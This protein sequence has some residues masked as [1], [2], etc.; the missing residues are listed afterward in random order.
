MDAIYGESTARAADDAKLATEIT[1]L[2]NS[3]SITVADINNHKDNIANP[4]HVTKG[5]VEL[6][7]VENLPLDTEPLLESPNYITSNAVAKVKNDLVNLLTAHKE[8]TNNP[9]EVTKDQV[10]LDKLE[11]RII[12][13][14]V[15]D[16]NNYISA[17]GVK[18]AVD[19][20]Q[21]NLD[22]H[23]VLENNPHNVTA[24]QIKLEKVVNM[25]MDDSP[26]DTE[27]YVKSR[28]VKTAIDTVQINLDNHKSASNPHD[29]TKAK[30]GL[31][32]VVNA[33]MD[34]EPTTDSTNY[35]TSGGVASTIA[36]MKTAINYDISLINNKLDK[37]I[38]K[39]DIP[40]HLSSFSN[41][42]TNYITANQI[43]EEYITEEKLLAKGYLSYVPAEYITES[44][45]DAKGYI[46][47][48]QDI[49]G[50]VNRT[51]LS[52]VAFTGS[53]KDLIDKPVLIPGEQGEQGIQGEKG[54]PGKSAYEI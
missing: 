39:E 40:T 4:H 14:A 21:T 43:P 9:H 25:P 45:L 22:K 18:S 33:K 35:V 48:H 12:V 49:S 2:E 52:Q 3:H 36:K 37:K 16:T 19:N 30:I 32:E 41:E 47:A 53:Y 24:E 13:D 7:N 54:D 50:K 27:N 34:A 8:N 1:E 17:R 44:E 31:G 28:G 15:D 10:G 29:I 23:A 6:G 38:T 26:S 46:K 20:V 51:E 42:Y 11:N 5:Q